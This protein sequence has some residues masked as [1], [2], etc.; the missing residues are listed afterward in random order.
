M[1]WKEK[2]AK[3]NEEWLVKGD[4]VSFWG[5]KIF[6]Q[7]E[8]GDVYPTFWNEHFQIVEMVDFMLCAFYP[9]I[10]TPQQKGKEEEKSGWP[11]RTPQ[12]L[13]WRPMEGMNLVYKQM[14]QLNP[15]DRYYK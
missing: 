11:L 14:S 12:N 5:D 13:G 10:T 6:L 8:N 3:G 7:L 9:S 15:L 2:K 4:K 1:F